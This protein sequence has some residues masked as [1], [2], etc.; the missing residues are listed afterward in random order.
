M[1]CGATTLSIVDQLLLLEEGVDAEPDQC[2]QMLATVEVLALEEALPMAV[3]LLQ[4]AAAELQRRANWQGEEVFLFFR[5]PK[6]VAGRLRALRLA[7]GGERY[8]YHGTTLG[9]L[10][11]ILRAGLVPGA[12]PVWRDAKLQTHVASGVFLAD[13]WAGAL[14]WAET[15]HRKSRGPR[16]S[17]T[18]RP[19]ILRVPAGNVSMVEDARAMA[20]GC[21]VSSSRVDVQAAK[22][23]LARS[24]GPLDW[25]PLQALDLAKRLPPLP[26]VYKLA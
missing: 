2:R 18:R 9:R 26:E 5:A 12:P 17:R 20:T 14:N 11:S 19:I 7:I 24:E 22:G 16:D 10:G 23:I 25:R 1:S 15:A 4:E 13:S 6:G 8:V 21:L 3:G